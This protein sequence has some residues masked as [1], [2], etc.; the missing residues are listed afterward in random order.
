MTQM[1]EGQFA[2]TSI[3]TIGHW[4]HIKHSRNEETSSQMEHTRVAVLDSLH[5]RS[6]VQTMAYSI[7]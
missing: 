2:A 1:T 6:E 5:A 3:V 4:W 7:F